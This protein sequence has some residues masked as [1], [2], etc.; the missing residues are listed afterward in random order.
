MKQFLE[1]NRIKILSFI[2]AI[3]S[4]PLHFSQ[5]LLYSLDGGWMTA[6]NLAVKNKLIFGKDFV[7]NY[8]PLGYFSTRINA[9]VSNLP[10]L[11]TA[12]MHM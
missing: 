6:L 9:Y 4:F 7:F 1:R 10:I 2:I 11:S 5:P 8:G 12:S 3:Y